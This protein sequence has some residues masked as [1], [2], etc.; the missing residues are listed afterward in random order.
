MNPLK[1]DLYA[2][3]LKNLIESITDLEWIIQLNDET[4][5]LWD[6]LSSTNPPKNMSCLFDASCGKGISPD[7]LQVPYDNILCGYAGGIGPHNISSTLIS[8]A[9]A[10]NGKPVWIDMESSLRIAVSDKFV[11][12]QDQFSINKCFSC[13][14]A[15]VQAGLAVNRIALLAI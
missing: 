8:V 7:T 10:T 15:G 11:L 5:P 13:I 9:K 1:Y 3:N 14:Q 6:R 2:E 12:E 4:K